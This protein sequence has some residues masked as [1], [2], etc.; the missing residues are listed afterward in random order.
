MGWAFQ[1]RP[2]P[3]ELLSGYLARAAHAHGS[4]AGAFCRRHLGDSWYFTRDIDRGVAASQHGRLAS[5][6]GRTGAAISDMTLRSWIEALTPSNYRRNV[7]SAITPWINAVGIDQARRRHRALQYCPDCL[8]ARGVVPKRWRLSFHTW[9]AEHHRPL[10]DCCAHC[11]A[12][13]VP[14]LTRRSLVSC[15]RCGTALVRKALPLTEP[16][17]DHALKLQKLMDQW[18]A[19]AVIGD[20][21]ARDRLS[22]LRV[23]VSVGW[24]RR[25]GRDGIAMNGCSC[26]DVG[27]TQRLELSPLAQRVQVME[28]LSQVVDAWPQAFHQLAEA[29]GLTQRSFARTPHSEWLK[30]EVDRLPT[31]FARSRP[32]DASRVAM[33]VQKQNEAIASNWRAKRAEFLMRKAV[34]RGN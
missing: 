25:G 6:S 9:C 32:P 31:G 5:L 1:L 15:H 21:D 11:S 16:A 26:L 2:E 22:G 33:P 12:L 20:T 27:V 13:F 29:G 3:H 34:S 4:V 23:V 28:W 10:V 19:D 24:L 8:A 17:H 18:L 14:H 30:A 7:P